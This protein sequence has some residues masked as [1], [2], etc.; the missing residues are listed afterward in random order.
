MFDKASK[1]LVWIKT[2]RTLFIKRSGSY[3]VIIV[4]YVDDLNIIGTPN[5]LSKF[6]EWLTKEFEMKGFGKTKFFLDLQIEHLKNGIF[7]HQ[8][9]YTEKVLK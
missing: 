3:F 2:I 8:S 9:T 6:V 4:V 1:I 5:E 7:V